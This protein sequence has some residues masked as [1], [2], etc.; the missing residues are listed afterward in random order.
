[1]IPHPNY[2]TSNNYNDI[3]IIRL[4]TEATFNDYVQPIC[5]WDSNKVSITE[6][7]GKFG[8][9]IGFGLTETENLSH[10][11]RQAVMPVVSFGTCLR[12]NTDVFGLYLSDEN[13]CAGSRNGTHC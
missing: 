3:A 4:S 9:V 6:V 13:F 1:M 8:T 2:V 10:T 5:L 12:S 7:I 11:L